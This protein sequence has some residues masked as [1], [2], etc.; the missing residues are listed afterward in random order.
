MVNRY[1]R[2]TPFSYTNKSLE[3]FYLFLSFVFYSYHYIYYMHVLGRGLGLGVVRQWPFSESLAWGILL[4]R[5][6]VKLF[7]N[8]SNLIAY[9]KTR[10]TKSP[11]LKY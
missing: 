3:A 4:G 11:D 6:T 1:C 5:W 8:F 9:F 7:S 10:A 2:G